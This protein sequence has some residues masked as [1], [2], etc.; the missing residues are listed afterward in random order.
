M[1]SP[2]RPPLAA[3]EDLARL[4]GH[5]LL[6]PELTS[7]QV[8]EGIH[9]ARRYQVAAVAVRPCDLEMAVRHLEGSPVIPAS[10]AGFP[11]GSQTTAA[12]LFETRDVLRRGARE[13]SV[14]IA[15]SRLLSR[16]FQAVQT[17]LTQIAEACHKERAALT[18]ILENVWLNEELKII[19]LRCAERAEADSVSTSTGF[20]PGG[21][22][23]AD[24]A[25]MR[26]YLPNQTGVE[27]CGAATLTNALEACEAG[28]TR[29]ATTQT[30]AILDEWKT[31]R[32][33]PSR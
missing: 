30:A 4:I 16:E 7:A 28:C 17:E 24:I 1:D 29:L 25:L 32:A 14:V 11:H 5:S 2:A 22:T 31:Q 12:K 26:R 6:R 8:L 18:V 33:E 13:V 10:V 27:A 3:G 19:A 23:L 9:L 20:A 15:L 21:Y